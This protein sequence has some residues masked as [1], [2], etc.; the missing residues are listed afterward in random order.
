MWLSARIQ[1]TAPWKSVRDLRVFLFSGQSTGLSSFI[2]SNAARKCTGCK[3]HFPQEGMIKSNVGYFHSTDCMADYG[4]KK[5]RKQRQATQNKLDKASRKEHTKRKRAL[6]H[7]DKKWMK[8]KTKELCHK[9]IRLRDAG[10][11]CISCGR[12]EHEIEFTG[13]GHVWDAGHY[14]SRGSHPELRFNARNIHKQCVKCNT[15]PNFGSQS[16]TVAQNYRINLIKK[17]GLKRVEWLEGPH[18]IPKDSIHRFE[19]LQK[20]YQYKINKIKKLGS[21]Q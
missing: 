21:K 17:V 13:A 14:L 9:F 20:W 4:L 16:R 1:L 5:H 8:N 2:V 7:G 15:A 11:P 6:N 3:Q 12:Y 19:I 18:P 10:A